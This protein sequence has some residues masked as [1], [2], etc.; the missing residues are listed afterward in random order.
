MKRLR[1]SAICIGVLAGLGLLSGQPAHSRER[2][3]QTSCSNA[4]LNGLYMYANSGYQSVSPS[5]VPLAVTGKNIFYG[6]GKF[7]SLATLS[8]GGTIIPNDA[9]PGTYTVNSDCTG[10]AIVHMTP[11]TPDVHLQW[12]VAPEG[13]QIFSTETDTGTVLTGTLQRVA[14]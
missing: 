7:D 13:D 4:T 10:T 8:I 12:F 6:N 5:L 14:R 3:S 9:A 11:P 1:V 2:G